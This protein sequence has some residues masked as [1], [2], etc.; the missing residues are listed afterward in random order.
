MM[1]SNHLA[2]SKVPIAIALSMTGFLVSTSVAIGAITDNPAI[3]ET[4]TDTV[5]EN[6]NPLNNAIEDANTTVDQVN[7]RIDNAPTEANAA[8]NETIDSVLDQQTQSEIGGAIGTYQQASSLL[9][10]V[11]GLGQRIQGILANFNLEQVLDAIN[12]DLKSITGNVYTVP[13]AKDAASDPLAEIEAG[14]LG[15][16]GIDEVDEAIAQAGDTALME[17]LAGKQ[18][19]GGISGRIYLENL[20]RKNQAEQT[21][22]K[23]AL[24]RT[25]QTKLANNSIAADDALKTSTAMMEDSEQQDVS[26]NVLRNISVQAHEQTVHTGLLALDAQLRA[27]DDSVRNVLMGRTLMEIQAERVSEQR[28]N[29]AAYSSV[30]TSGG[31]FYLPGLEDERKA[32]R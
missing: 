17:T 23:T 28:R 32:Q 31:M 8:I 5:N 24:S 13:G 11:I 1:R 4:V 12:I 22:D 15:L 21:A 29:A 10:R 6:I 16:P 30:I 20:Y 27:R 14:A 7:G 9:S 25:G 2:M 26:Q 19:G 3:T 18:E